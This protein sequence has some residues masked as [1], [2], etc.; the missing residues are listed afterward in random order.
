MAD[1]M[2]TSAHSICASV[3]SSMLRSTSRR[4]QWLGKSAATVTR[5]SGGNTAPLPMIGSAYSCPQ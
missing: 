4:S 5:P 1:T 2:T 3:S